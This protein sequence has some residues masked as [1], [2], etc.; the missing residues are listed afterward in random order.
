MNLRDR[1]LFKEY[2][3][4]F[5]ISKINIPEKHY[6]KVIIALALLFILISLGIGL[7]QSIWFDEAYSLQ[8]A[9]RPINELINLTSVDVHPPIYYLFLKVWMGLFGDSNLALRFSSVI[10]MTL[11]L[12]VTTSLIK[13]IFNY[14]TAI[15]SMF[16]M[17]ISPMLLRYG[18]ELRM[19]ALATLICCSATYVLYKIQHD[20][21]INLKYYGFLYS[22]LV[23]LGMLTLYYTAV[24]W[25]VHACYSV[26]LAISRKQSLWRQPIWA[27]YILSVLLFLPWLPIALKQFTNGA[28][29]NISEAMTPVNLLGVF[30]FNFVYQPFWQLN[31]VIGLLMLII[32]ITM[33]WLF[34][35]NY[36]ERKQQFLLFM[37]IVSIGIMFLICLIKPMYVERYLVYFSPFLMSLVGVWLVKLANKKSLQYRILSIVIIAGLI[38]GVVKLNE[39]GNF[40]FQRM[41]KPDIAQVIEHID[42]NLP[43]VANSPYESIELMTYLKQPSYF[44]SSHDNLSGGYAMLNQS[45]Y[46][47]KN[48][49]ELAQFSCFNFVYYD[50]QAHDEMIKLGLVKIKSSE[51]AQLKVAQFCR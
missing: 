9:R 22:M 18:F 13:G 50:D 44:R 30:S 16:V 8:L 48:D 38:L 24:I 6:R 14:K 29:A 46:Q 12:V 43:I 2:P 45:S 39:L 1:K 20:K 47:L 40:N 49:A 35:L 36:R 11:A 10:M 19:Y 15:I 32:I 3:F 25:L 51:H 34:S 7:R 31:Q 23:V 26:Y 5:V 21:L 4:R 41:Q 37:V 42:Q 33:I 28:L 17:V 27:C